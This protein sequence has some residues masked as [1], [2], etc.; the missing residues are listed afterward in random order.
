[1]K[2][3]PELFCKQT[4]SSEKRLQHWNMLPVCSELS[5]F[6]FRFSVS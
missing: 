4:I 5:I 6:Q 2:L 3:S 1:M